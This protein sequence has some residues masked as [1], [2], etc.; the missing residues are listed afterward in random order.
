MEEGIA[1][2]IYM[3]HLKKLAPVEHGH[4]AWHCRTLEPCL[5]RPT[6]SNGP[7]TFLYLAPSSFSLSSSR[8][9]TFSCSPTLFSSLLENDVSCAKVHGTSSELSFWIGGRCT[10]HLPGVTACA[11]CRTCVLHDSR[12]AA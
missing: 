6:F 7:C 12:G 11:C 10:G 4:E 9:G 8:K 5:A 3:R 1:I 2:L